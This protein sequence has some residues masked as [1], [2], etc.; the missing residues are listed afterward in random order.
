MQSR[1][2]MR[3]YNHAKVQAVLTACR[4]GVRL[5]DAC[6][7][8][9]ISVYDFSFWRRRDAGM[10][11]ELDDALRTGNTTREE[12]MEARREAKR[13]RMEGPRKHAPPPKPRPVGKEHYFTLTGD[14]GRRCAYC[15]RTQKAAPAGHCDPRSGTF[16]TARD[17]ND[18]ALKSL[19]RA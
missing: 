9:D 7:V 15:G 11:T 19:R 4:A 10:S 12:A 6:A 8:H 2:P 5:R 18:Q 3:P 17:T 13:V 14:G 16:S 1:A